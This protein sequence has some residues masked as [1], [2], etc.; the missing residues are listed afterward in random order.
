M[1][2]GQ[3]QGIQMPTGAQ[4][5]FAKCGAWCKAFV[6]GLGSGKTLIGVYEVIRYAKR[7][8]NSITIC[9]EPTY[10]MVRDI[11]LPEFERQLQAQPGLQH[12]VLKQEWK[13][14]LGY[15]GAQ[16]WLRQ[17]DQ[18]D[19][20]R[21]PS[22]AQIWMD[23]AALCKR[24]AFDI[25][26][27]R[28]RLPG[29]PLRALVTT[30]PRG[31]NWVWDVFAGPAALD[32]AVLFRRSSLDNP[33][34]AELTK[35]I[36]QQNYSGVTYRQEVEGLFEVFEGLVY[37]DFDQ[38]AHVD[39]PPAKHAWRGFAAGVDWGWTDPAVIV[40]AGL[41]ADGILWQV[42]E[43]VAARLPIGELVV[44]AERLARKYGIMAFFCDPSQPANIYELQKAGLNAL[45]AN[46]A[47][48]PGIAALNGRIGNG[49]FRLSPSCPETLKELLCYSF[50]V[51][52]EGRVK[53]DMPEDANNHCMDAARYLTA[54]IDG[55]G[56]AGD[57][58]VLTMDDVMPDF[59]PRRLGA[60]R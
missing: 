8:P 57:G 15:N 41:D 36:L 24:A 23:E 11:L 18:F 25:L 28:L 39:E 19:K 53:R 6:G 12:S 10:P 60:A 14:R 7:H 33:Y 26:T 46:N 5:D 17:A 32:G 48:I 51:D 29:Y 55:I 58:A 4:L 21:G 2:A 45:P 50:P 34:L 54:G 16:I 43:F 37:R 38:D 44:Q 49:R 22:V 1:A 31:R 9:T 42:A 30:T 3:P 27:S 20:L 13:I 47:V 40:V 59:T 56:V 52:G 35:G